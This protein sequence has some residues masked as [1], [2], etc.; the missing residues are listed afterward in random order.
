[1]RNFKLIAAAAAVCLI[2]TASAALAAIEKIPGVPKSVPFLF[3]ISLTPGHKAAIEKITEGVVKSKEFEK[4]AEA[5]KQKNGFE[6]PAQMI[7]QAKAFTS[8]SMGVF[9]NTANLREEPCVLLLGTFDAEKDAAAFVESFKGAMVAGAKKQSRELSFTESNEGGLKVLT[10]AMK[11]KDIDPFKTGEP[12]LIQSGNAAGLFI[13]RK[14]DPAKSGAALKAVAATLKN[15]AD[16]VLANKNVKAAF[17][18]LAKD[19]TFFFYFDGS[20]YKQGAVE[21]NRQEM[22]DLVTS[23]AAAGKIDDQISRI[24]TDWAVA[25]GDLKD[26]EA[27]SNIGFIKTLLSAEKSENHAAA[28]VPADASAMLS[29]KLNMGKDF[30]ATTQM[31][32]AKPVI[33]MMSGIAFEE[34]ILSWFTGD[35]FFAFGGTVSEFFV[36]LRC[37][38]KEAADKFFTKFRGILKTAQ[39]AF[40]FK[41]ETAGQA[42][43]FCAPIANTPP[44]LKDLVVT[45]GHAG[46][47]FA[48]C[49]SKQAFEKLA[50]AGTKKESSLAGSPDAANAI[51]S[52]SA[53]M[54]FFI[55]YDRFMKLAGDFNEK[56]GS[57]FKGHNY[58]EFIKSFCAS[59]EFSAKEISGSSIS[60]VVPEKAGEWFFK[61]LN[62]PQAREAVERIRN[63]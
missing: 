37:K 19:A 41:E 8:F 3:S 42:K 11:A 33:A 46:D 48:I 36:G 58:N 28:A 15:P 25:L 60:V 30:M 23:V 18:K 14:K 12:R 5:F 1:M 31:T 57:E 45:V 39:A 62:T 10:P 59:A 26:K 52:P 27:A 22:S 9:L 13:F 61:M 40:E 4:M 35:L 50:A 24:V 17:D 51:F 47:Y 38:N 2:V 53:F 63:D 54:T 56:V 49:S 21:N 6:F 34:D 43:V 20:L 29:L 32:G 16:G 7:T 55:N 44:F